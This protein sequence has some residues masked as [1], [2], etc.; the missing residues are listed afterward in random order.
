[1]KFEHCN[2]CRPEIGI[3]GGTAVSHISGN[4]VDLENDLRNQNRPL[5]HCPQ[6]KF[7]PR[8]DGYV[9]GKEYIKPTCHPKV[10]TS[11]R[12]LK[13]CQFASYPETPLTPSMNLFTCP[14]K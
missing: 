9:Q 12:H 3:V 1:M 5:T 11:L 8:D 4:M 13:P 2:K 6:Y 10:D 14:K 7:L